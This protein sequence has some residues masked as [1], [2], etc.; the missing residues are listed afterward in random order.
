MFSLN[1]IYSIVVIENNSSVNTRQCV[2][3]PHFDIR[4]QDHLVKICSST[5]IL[6]IVNVRNSNVCKNCLFTIS[7]ILNYPFMANKEVNYRSF[8]ILGPGRR[9]DLYCSTNN[10]II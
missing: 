8:M 2:K 3:S 4:L 10:I 1:N 7:F 5:K 9:K 6:N